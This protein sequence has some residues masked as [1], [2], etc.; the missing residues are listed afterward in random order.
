MNEEIKKIMQLL[1]ITEEEAFEL[2][3]DDKKIDKGE[4]M[5][6]DLTPE[7]EK[8]VKQIKNGMARC[9]DAY[10]KTRT[11][12]VKE[13]IEKLFLIENIKSQLTTVKC[14]NIVVTNPQREIN[15]EYNGRKFKIVLS[16]PRK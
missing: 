2:L 15:F 12:T 11:R 13:D 4:K 7:Q 9:V 10:G 14:D 3:E 6:F 1:D 8:N 16:A 5:D